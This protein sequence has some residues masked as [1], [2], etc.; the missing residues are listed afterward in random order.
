MKNKHYVIEKVADLRDS[1]ADNGA[2]EKI[3]EDFNEIIEN[4]E[5]LL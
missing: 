2:D 1:F 3:I 4:I 5:R